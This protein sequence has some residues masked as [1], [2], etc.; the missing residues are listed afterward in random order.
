MCEIVHILFAFSLLIYIISL[1]LLVKFQLWVLRAVLDSGDLKVSSFSS[2]M[3]CLKILL[4]LKLEYREVINSLNSF[5][6]FV[7]D[8]FDSYDNKCQ[9]V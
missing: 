9:I 1:L 2:F 6:L 5:R 3:I 8:F 4:I 7:I